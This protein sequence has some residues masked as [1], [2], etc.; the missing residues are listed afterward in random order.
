VITGRVLDTSALLDAATGRTIFFRAL[1]VAA[2]ELGMTLAIPTTAWAEAWAL[3]PD[4]ALP[5]LSLVGEHPHA[6]L[7]ALD[8]DGAQRAGL[9]ARDAGSGGLAWT[10]RSAQVVTVALERAWPVVTAEPDE[11]LGIDPDVQLQTLPRR[12]RPAA[13]A[14]SRI[15]LKRPASS[16]PAADVRTCGHPW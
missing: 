16:S 12:A 11:L 10:V 14:S 6:V 9:L 4:D 2:A 7:V 13:A 5:S 1:V 3:A 15:P 8:D